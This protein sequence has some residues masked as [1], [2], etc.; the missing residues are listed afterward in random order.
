MG[1]GLFLMVTAVL[2]IR[3]TDFIPSLETIPLYEILIITCTLTSF[4]KIFDRLS[5]D[6]LA[7]NPVSACVLGLFM[8]VVLSNLANMNLDGAVD[9]GFEFAKVVIYYLL[10]I[11]HLN[12]PQRLRS[13]ILWLALCITVVNVIGVL[14]YY[15]YLHLESFA[16]LESSDSDEIDPETG[17]TI[18]TH[19]L[20]GTGLFHDPNQLCTILNVAIPIAIY[21]MSD[22]R[23]GSKRWLW[24]GP[25]FL[26]V[27]ALQL[28]KSRGG[29]M[30]T[31]AAIL[32]LLRARYRGRG[33]LVLGG[34]VL[35][36]F[37]VVFGGRQTNFSVSG[38][39]GHQRLELWY[40]AF[41]AIFRHPVF[42]IGTEQFVEMF[43]RV[44]HN[45]FIQGFAEMG[46]FGGSL[47][48][49]A[50]VH[51][52]AAV[53]RLTPERAPD[54]DPDLVRM[55]PCVLAAVAGYAVNMMTLSLNYIVPTY[56]LLGIAAGFLQVAES[57]HPGAAGPTGFAFVRRTVVASAVYLVMMFVY[58]RVMMR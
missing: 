35:P 16:V 2:F 43:G 20:Q 52:L 5:G 32:I 14:Q 37:L 33:M 22:R 8:A 55:R 30:G 44:A 38:G 48:L 58:T 12:S 11:G 7:K 4:D 34:L 46:F 3:P 40:D 39:S 1:F 21:G 31:I 36:V 50:H 42:G 19:R 28:T 26:F 10:L 23:T 17:Q 24:L 45:A 27:L 47:F 51:A 13:F 25:L 54:L 29:L 41:E 57:D 49:G 53:Y 6:S 9:M 15:G 18:V 56:T